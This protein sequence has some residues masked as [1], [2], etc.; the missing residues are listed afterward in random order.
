MSFYR[1]AVWIDHREAHVFRVEADSF[2][3]SIVCAPEDSPRGPRPVADLRVPV[4]NEQRFFAEVARK[5]RGS[6]T[7]LILGPSNAKLQFRDYV[8]AH[9]STLSFGV[10]GVETVAHP[11][12]DQIV[13]F[14]RE[15]F[16]SLYGRP[17]QS[18]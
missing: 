15:Y 2:A 16:R 1:T 4:E 5:A 6:D 12:D 7:V 8:K 9:A 10:A 14:V 11:T 17:A 3:E 13:A 18:H